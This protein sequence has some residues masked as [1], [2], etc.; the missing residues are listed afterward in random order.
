MDRSDELKTKEFA[1]ATVMAIFR[2]AVAAFYVDVQH[3][4]FRCVRW[5]SKIPMEIPED[6]LYSTAVNTFITSMIPDSHRADAQ[7]KISCEY[8]RNHINK[9]T[10]EFSFKV[11]ITMGK[12]ERWLNF[13]VTLIEDRKSVV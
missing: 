13:F 10:P 11:P 2:S 9:E 12:N 1:E 7:L 5:S 6:G 3:N 8:I 4:W